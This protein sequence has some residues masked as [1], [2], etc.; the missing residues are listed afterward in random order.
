MQYGIPVVAILTLADLI[1]HM[2][3]RGAGLELSSMVAYRDRYGV[4]D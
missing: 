2:R 4:A 1:G 3:A